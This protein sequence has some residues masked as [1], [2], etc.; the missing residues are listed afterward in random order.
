MLLT[1]TSA[2][3]MSKHNGTSFDPIISQ[4]PDVSHA[5]LNEAKFA[6]KS[7]LSVGSNYTCAYTLFC[8]LVYSPLDQSLSMPLCLVVW[9]HCKEIKRPIFFPRAFPMRCN[10]RKSF[11]QYPQFR[12]IRCAV[13]PDPF[14]PTVG[15]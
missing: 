2:S 13:R 4:R 5:N 1:V 6:I 8:R 3:D 10:V 12:W 9:M 15:Q 14:R 11:V 7:V